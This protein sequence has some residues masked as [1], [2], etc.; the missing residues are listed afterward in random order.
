MFWVVTKPYGVVKKGEGA[1]GARGYS[2][3]I[4]IGEEAPGNSAQGGKGNRG[5]S[6]STPNLHPKKRTN[7]W[8]I[9]L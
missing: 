5:G 8:A 2:P 7:H 9:N 6:S 1:P 4:R 3:R